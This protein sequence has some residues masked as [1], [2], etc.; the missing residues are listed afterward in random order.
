M[1]AYLNAFLIIPEKKLTVPIVA[2][3]QIRTNMVIE[4][5][6]GKTNNVVSEQV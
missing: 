2:C 3:V 1:C 5:P 6:H 4:P